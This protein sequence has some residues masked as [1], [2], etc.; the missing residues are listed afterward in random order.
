MESKPQKQFFRVDEVADYFSISV[1]TVFRLI[2]KGELRCT[3]IGNCLRLSLW[4]IER[5]RKKLEK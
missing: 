3:K 2:D 1:R 5:Y 4:E